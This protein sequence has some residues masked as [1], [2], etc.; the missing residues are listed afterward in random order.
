M[1][2]T[3]TISVVPDMGGTGS[4]GK[5]DRTTYL[6]NLLKLRREGAVWLTQLRDQ[7]AAIVQEL[8]IPSTRDEDWRF[9]DLSKLLGY[10]WELPNTE[11][12]LEA[13]DHL[14]VPE[15][16]ARL[17]FMNGAFNQELSKIVG[18]PDGAFVGGVAQLTNADQI[19]KI[20]TYLGKQKGA[21][22]V[23]TALNTASLTDA[24]IVWIPRNAVIE[25]PIHLSFLTRTSNRTIVSQPRCLV[26]V[27][28]G[29]QVA[30]VE[31]YTSSDKHAP[32]FTNT[33]TEIYV[34]DNA[35]VNHT[36]LQ[37]E[38]QTAFHIA[39]TA[40]S[41]A[42]DSRYIC[43][44]INLGAG[45]SRHNLDV[46]QIGSQ[47]DTQLYGLGIVD[48]DRTADTHSLIAFDQPHGTAKQL[49]KFIADD[50][51]HGIFNGRIYVPKLAQETDAAQLSR[52]LLLSDKARI[53]TKPELEIIADNVKCA[54]GAT[55]SQLE[56]DE[57]FYL[58]SRGIAGDEARRLLQFAFAVEVLN[59]IPVESLRNTLI[60]H[61]R[62]RG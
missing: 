37:W 18:L 7:A 16:S 34:G 21:E 47:A 9:T 56:E 58:Q 32:Y 57:I 28:S 1:V 33:V 11:Q 31:E 13:C 62:V 55:V 26:I 4:A 42:K 14:V 30:F 8:A 12:G 2:D 46:Y 23:F 52:N 35:S 25:Q 49:H 24:A 48:G 40:V 44:A 29:A 15:A 41:Q 54:H 22:E 27:E 20:Q 38:S 3:A 53:D 10:N 43:N 60:D 19:A 61:V 59:H 6:A 36:R 50:K 51:A 5:V 45:L 17:V 39:K